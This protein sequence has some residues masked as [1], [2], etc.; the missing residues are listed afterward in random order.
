[1]DQNKMGE[2]L[3]ELR[4]QKGLTQEEVGKIIGVQK[5]AIQKYEKGDIKNMKTDA[6][7]KLAKFYNVTPAYIMGIDEVEAKG[8]KED[9]Q[10]SEYLELLA[11]RP[12]LKMLFN[13][14]KDATREEVEK[15]VK[16]IETILGK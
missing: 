13:L 9:K 14:T 5:A 6:A 15:A 3:K 4:L 12:E 8:S 10:L 7:R 1:M 16:I 11:T 2:R